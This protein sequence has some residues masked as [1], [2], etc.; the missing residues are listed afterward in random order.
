M[1]IP[2]A[3]SI[4]RAADKDW[5]QIV[6]LVEVLNLD[7]YDMYTSQF[8]LCQKGAKILGIGRIKAH[9]D[10]LELCT[11][12]VDPSHRGKGIGKAL[13]SS[14]LEGVTGPVCVVTEIP[15]YFEKLGFKQ[16]DISIQSLQRKKEICTTQLSCKA[17]VIMVRNLS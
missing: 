14:L 1:G 11:L 13:V 10:C 6:D 5:G 8:M 17:P 4:Q 2:E 12:G 16:V 15:G 3:Y 7:S 9:P